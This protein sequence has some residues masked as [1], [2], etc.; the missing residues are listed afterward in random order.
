MLDRM[1]GYIDI[2]ASALM[3]A[4]ITLGV[5]LIF[6][7]TQLNES[8]FMRLLY[9]NQIIWAVLGTGAFYLFIVIPSRTFYD[10]AY[11]IYF[12]VLLLLAVVLVKGTTAMG[13][14]RWFAL[15]PIRIQPSELAKVATV[16]ALARYL[17]SKPVSFEKLSTLI[18]PSLLLLIPVAMIM[19][20]PDLSTALVFCAM[21]VP[22]LFWSGFSLSEVFFLAS[23]VFS[24]IFA[25]HTFLWAL[26]FIILFFL[27]IRLSRN[28]TVT[29]F[30]LAVNFVVGIILPMVWN[31]LHD[32]QKKRILT[33][34]DPSQDPSGAGYQVLQSQVAIGSGKFLGKGFLQG[35][36]TR[37]SF[38]PEQHTDFIFSVLGEQFG[39]IGCL[40]VLVLFMLLILRMLHLAGEGNNRFLNLCVIGFTAQMA[41]HIFVN[42]SMTVGMMPVTGLPLPFLSYGGSFLISCMA[43][44]GFVVSLRKKSAEY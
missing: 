1:K 24:L 11:V 13:A 44:M 42:I 15:G 18:M 5:I 31:R 12:L 22:M 39:F 37:L 38:L 33:F 7:A 30:V 8:P 32:Y 10:L 17:S 35:T 23:P 27:L 26:F 2:P 14:T 28:L 21:F 36:Q 34:A 25:F 20:Q 16:L 41:F 4:L 40:C 9:R 6:S 19:K 3:Y 29:T 43:L